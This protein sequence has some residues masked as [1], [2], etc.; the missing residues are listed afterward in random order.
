MER[1]GS[2]IAIWKI[3][4]R[5]FSPPE[6]PTLTSLLA[7]S[8]RIC[9]NAIFSFISFRKSPAFIG[10]R[11]SA[12]RFALTAVFMKFVMVTPGISIGYWNDMKIPAQER[13]SGDIASRSLP[14]NVMLP[15]VT[16]YNG[17]PVSTLDNVLL[18]APL[19]PMTAWISPF[20]MTRSMPF[21]ISLSPTE[22]CNPLI[23]NNISFAIILTL[24]LHAKI[25]L[26]YYICR[27]NIKGVLC[28]S[29]AEII[30]SK[31]DAGNAAAGIENNLVRRPRKNF[32]Q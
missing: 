11:P 30:P 27:K 7:N 14:M 31:P 9:T 2:S 12:A 1:V 24:F 10:S 19:G 26:I 16:V 15:S 28:Y 29:M 4:L 8:G 3:S 17:L 5:F 6:K 32:S 22:A 20:L 25:Q 18:P 13:S 21:R 23:S